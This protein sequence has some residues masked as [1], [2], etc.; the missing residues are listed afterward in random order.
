MGSLNYWS[1]HSQYVQ[2]DLPALTGQVD[3]WNQTPD[4]YGGS[5]PFDMV[6]GILD[7][8]NNSIIAENDDNNPNPINYT[9]S[10]AKLLHQIQLVEV[11]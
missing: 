8:T 10:E 7:K 5:T 1:E 11:V 2:F 4:E 3:V 9:D 6:I